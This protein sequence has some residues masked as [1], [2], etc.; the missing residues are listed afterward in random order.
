M[1]LLYT[2]WSD[3]NLKTRELIL[4]EPALVL[5]AHEQTRRAR[6]RPQTKAQQLLSDLGALRSI[7]GRVDQRTRRGEL[8]GLL[9][10]EREEISHVFSQT[11][12]EVTR[13]FERMGKAI[14]DAR[15]E[16]TRSDSTTA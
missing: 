4:K 7:A 11:S 8:S 12:R 10:P 14:E 1:G 9:A 2:V 3:G 6:E 13:L 16:H 15:Q 5:R